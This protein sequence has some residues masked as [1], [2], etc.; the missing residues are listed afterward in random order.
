MSVCCLSV[1]PSNAWMTKRK[2]NTS[3]FLYTAFIHQKNW[4]QNK[5]NYTWEIAYSFLLLIN[6]WINYKFN[7]TIVV[8]RLSAFAVFWC[9]VRWAICCVFYRRP[10]A[11]LRDMWLLVD[12]LGWLADEKRTRVH[13]PSIPVADHTLSRRTNSAKPRAEWTVR[14]WN[15]TS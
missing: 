13:V 2:K 9:S 14:Q 8:V 12:R 10:F 5:E 15:T 4:Q 11:E 3:R 7:W 1:C 6:K